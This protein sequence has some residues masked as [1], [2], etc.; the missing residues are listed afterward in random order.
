MLLENKLNIKSI[1][2]AVTKEYLKSNKIASGLSLTGNKNDISFFYDFIDG[3]LKVWLKRTGNNSFW[4]GKLSVGGRTKLYNKEDK[5]E[6][7]I[8]VDATDSFA[9]VRFVIQTSEEAA[10][11]LIGVQ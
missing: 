9:D 5:F 3:E 4:R 7:I 10:E 1:V 6:P 2:N 8:T 11:F